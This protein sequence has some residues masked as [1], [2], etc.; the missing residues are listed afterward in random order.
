MM[1]DKHIGNSSW[2]LINIFNDV[3]KSFPEVNA[4]LKSFDKQSFMLS[5]PYSKYIFYNEEQLKK[6][7]FSRTALRGV[8]A[9]ELSHKISYKRMNPLTRLFVMILYQFHSF[10][11]RLE[12]EADTITV[13]RGFGNELKIL[14]KESKQKFDK[15]RY[16]RL[17]SVRLSAEEIDKLMRKKRQK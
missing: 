16:S 8:I 11:K 14:N 1:V 9:H 4:E 3:K 2:N 10:K 12:Q 5:S 6:Y 13:Q 15:E 7:K 17:E